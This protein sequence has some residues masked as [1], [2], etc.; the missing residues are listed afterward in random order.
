MNYKLSDESFDDL[1]KICLELIDNINFS[2][3]GNGKLFSE[4]K[5][6]KYVWNTNT[7]IEVS[8]LEEQFINKFFVHLND[9]NEIVRIFIK[10]FLND[11]DISL[12]LMELKAKLIQ[13]VEKQIKIKMISNF[14]N[15]LDKMFSYIENSGFKIEKR[16]CL[17]LIRD[18]IDMKLKEDIL[19]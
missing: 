14:D 15:T 17:K 7:K 5:T 8:E 12:K 19:K 4:C 10:D 11:K 13:V 1:K 3:N 2:F 18:A 9:E 16:Y 6:N